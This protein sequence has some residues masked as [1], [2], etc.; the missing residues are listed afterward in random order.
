MT[1]S[2]PKKPIIEFG[3]RQ[4]HPSATTIISATASEQVIWC[5]ITVVFWDNRIYTL[6]GTRETE[7]EAITAEASFKLLT[8]ASLDTT[9]STEPQIPDGAISWTEARQHVGETATIYGTVVGTNY[10][11]SSNGQPIYIDIGAAYPDTSRVTVVI[12]GEDRGSF[13]FAPET[14]YQ[15]QTVLVTGEIYL[16]DGVCNIKVQFPSRILVVP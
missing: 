13:S 12:W 2:I 8:P 16:C 3:S 1:D 5:Y 15:G 10:A 11:S 7:D 9:L 4:G 14:T 6:A